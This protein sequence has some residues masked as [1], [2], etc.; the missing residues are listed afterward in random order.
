MSSTNAEEEARMVVFSIDHNGAKTMPERGTWGKAQSEA[1]EMANRV[2][3]AVTLIAKT[4]R[5]DEQEFIVVPQEWMEN[6]S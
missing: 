5:G 2:G 6:E 1:S 3:T 4:D